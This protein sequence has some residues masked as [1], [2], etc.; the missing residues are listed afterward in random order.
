MNLTQFI[1]DLYLSLQGRHVP[2]YSNDK[3]MPVCNYCFKEIGRQGIYYPPGKL[4]FDSKECCDAVVNDSGR[5][6][7]ESKE[8]NTLVSLLELKVLKQPK[9]GDSPPKKSSAPKRIE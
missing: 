9:K 3:L 1:S 4:V 8:K 7:C 6:L 5:V 2:K